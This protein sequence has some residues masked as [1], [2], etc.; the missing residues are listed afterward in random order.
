MRVL[1]I[2]D[3]ELAARKLAM[4]VKRY[5]PVIEVVDIL[6]S[7]KAAVAWFKEC[8]APDLVFLDIHLADGLSFEIF[9]EIKLY[10]PIIFTTAYD[11][12]ALKAFELNSVDYLLKPVSPEDIARSLDKYKILHP[13]K[14]P[15]QLPAQMENLL[16]TMLQPQ[17]QFKERFLVKVGQKILSLSVNDVAYFYSD[18]RLVLIMTHD[19]QKLPV[20]Y[21]LDELTELLDPNVFFRVSRQFIV[22]FEAIA[23]M[24]AY[25]NSRIKLSL[26]PI[27]PKEVIVSGEKAGTFKKWLDR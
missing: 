5:D 7:V 16:R 3:E 15:N 25:S 19:Q 20:D 4:L 22:K 21:T 1:I 18:E 26:H 14:R 6:D 10:T 27:E 11:E 13:E 12:Y 9:R 8:P 2:E 17:P 23:A 24:Y